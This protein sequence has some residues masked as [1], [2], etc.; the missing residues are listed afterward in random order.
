MALTGCG[1]TT[2]LDPAST[3]ASPSTRCEA[4]TGTAVPDCR[5]QPENVGLLGTLPSTA[6]RLLQERRE[7][8]PTASADR[9]DAITRNY[10]S[11]TSRQVVYVTVTYGDVT[12][13]N[14]ATMQPIGYQ[15]ED[16]LREGFEVFVGAEDLDYQ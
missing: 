11:L 13:V 14:E 7:A 16:G 6:W 12:P 5:V 10:E 1:S 3:Q 8:V 2:V 15:T 9:V 4:S